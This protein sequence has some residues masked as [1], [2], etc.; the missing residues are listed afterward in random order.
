MFDCLIIGS[1]CAGLSAAIYIARANKKVCIVSGN[2]LGG[3]L[4]KTSYVENFP[5]FESIL[6]CELME[7]MNQQVKT[8]GVEFIKDSLISYEKINQTF[9]I[10]LNKSKLSA[11]SLI[12][13]TGSLP[14]KLGIEEKF[15]NK[16][17]SYCATCD[18][19]FFKNKTV[20][21]VGGG[22]TAIE[23]AIYLSSICKKVILIHRRNEFRADQILQKKLF[24]TANIE[25]KAPFTISELIGN[26]KLNFVKLNNNELIET[27]GLFV[28]IGNDP[29]T[30][31]LKNRENIKLDEFGYIDS[32]FEPGLFFA[33]DILKNNYKQA[34]IAAGSGATA[35]LDAIS[36][37]SNN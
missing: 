32:Y 36:F 8:L 19:F 5:G 37:L 10:T 26:D 23:E 13:A 9:E 7:K 35:A 15:I 25:I 2:M 27:E 4:T 16:G 34:V 30:S 14:K 24:E 17:V 12:I 31:F 33:G 22:N 18:G 21:V 28:A 20:C 6:G 1:G 11:K 3:L 29:N